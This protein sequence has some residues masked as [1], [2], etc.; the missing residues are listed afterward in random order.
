MRIILL[1]L[2]LFP[3]QVLAQTPPTREKLDMAH[4]YRLALRDYAAT[5]PDVVYSTPN[6]RVLFVKKEDYNNSLADTLMGL[7]IIFIDPATDAATIGKYITK[8][9]KVTILHMQQMLLKEMDA[10]VW[11]MPMDASF[12]PKKETLSEP[13]YQK[14]VCQYV[15][16][17]GNDRDGYLY[18]EKHCKVLEE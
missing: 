11:I 4:V 6:E 15:Y 2:F 5:H 18:K 17:Y 3:F 7:H 8:K 16:D 13:I 14:E 10:N 12:N 9:K 1:C